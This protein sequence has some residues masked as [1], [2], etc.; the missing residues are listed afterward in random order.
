MTTSG[1]KIFFRYI[2]YSVPSVYVIE[3]SEKVGSSWPW[4]VIINHLLCTLHAL[5]AYFYFGNQVFEVPGSGIRW[6]GVPIQKKSSTVRVSIVLGCM[7]WESNGVIGVLENKLFVNV[8]LCNGKSHMKPGCSGG[9]K[10]SPRGAHAQ[11]T[12]HRCLVGC[13]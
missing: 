3:I 7:C 4:D 8:W 12:Y 2:P 6:S 9:D 11:S 13:E 1:Y 10:T 5:L